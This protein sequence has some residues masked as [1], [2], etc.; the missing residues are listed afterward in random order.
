MPDGPPGG[1]GRPGADGPHAPGAPEGPHA[2]DC[3]SPPAAVPGVPGLWAARTDPGGHFRGRAADLQRAAEPLLA[4][5]G[6]G[7]LDPEELTELPGAEQLALLGALRGSALPGAAGGAGE[8]SGWDTVVVDCPPVHQALAALALPEQFD[9]YLNRLL[10]AERQAARAL[11]PLLAGLV[12]VPAPPQALYAAAERARSALA[13]TLAVVRSP[14]TT[15]RLV[16]EPGPGAAD[17]LRLAR[18]GLA[19]FGHR[20]ESVTANRLLPAAS[21]D[22]WLA[23]LADR[24]REH[25]E[26]LREACAETGAGIGGVPHLGRVP[27]DA[28]D[29][30]LLG[31]APPEPSGADPG[32]GRAD[33]WTV[34]DRLAGD[35]VMVWRLP[36]PGA[37]RSD[38]DLV[39]REDELVVDVGPF[40]RILPLPAALRRCTVEGASLRDGELCVRFAPDP[41]LWPRRT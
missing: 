32:E 5:L 23:A 10:P 27:R 21:P 19:L 13:G 2:P 31:V 34:E 16:V 1:E 22:P 25:L 35:G 38:L 29:L 37:R 20:L 24:Q 18:A 36:L 6:A 7:P 14:A 40:R 9:R 12:G 33:P 4:L 3:L 30:A 11:H 8:P 39:R 26:E 17:E 28:D 41:D 15:V